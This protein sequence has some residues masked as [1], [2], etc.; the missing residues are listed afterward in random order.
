VNSAGLAIGGALAMIGASLPWLTLYAGLHS[1]PGII[2][3]YGWLIFGIGAVALICGLLAIRSKPR[4][5]GRSSAILGIAL[6]AFTAWLFQGLMQIVHRPEA[7]M[8][9]PRPGPGLFVAASGAAIIAVTS[10]LDRALN[11]LGRP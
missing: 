9:V 2:G 1:Y 8:L 7:V 3:V 4:W 5:L 11:A 6:L 10:L